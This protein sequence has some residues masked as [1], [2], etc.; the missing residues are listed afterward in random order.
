MKTHGT[1]IIGIRSH[2]LSLDATTGAEIWRTKLKSG[3]FVTVYAREDRVF[4]GAS[5]ELFC[6][7]RASGNLIWHNKL[8]KLGFGLVSFA[9]DP[10]KR[11]PHD[12]IVGIKGH[13]VSIDAATGHESWR[14][15]LPSRV[16]SQSVTLALEGSATV[17]AGTSGELFGV[18]RTMGRVLWRAPLAGLGIGLVTLG[19]SEIAI[20]TAMMQAQ[21]AA[22]GG[23]AAS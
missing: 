14:T 19:G 1:V 6:L 2:A 17:L 20:A 15:N 21:A 3:Q 8:Q 10:A 5:G 23:A 12:V 18:D 4:A 13:V 16:G 22:A 7:D 11:S 9:A